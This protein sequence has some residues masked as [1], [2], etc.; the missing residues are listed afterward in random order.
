M[1]DMHGLYLGSTGVSAWMENRREQGSLSEQGA[2]NIRNTAGLLD[3]QT[4]YIR[5]F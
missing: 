4:I 5:G 2:Y 3:Y 1:Q